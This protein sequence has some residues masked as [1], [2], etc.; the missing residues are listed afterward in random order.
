MPQ[1]VTIARIVSNKKLQKAPEAP[2]GGPVNDRLH[3]PLSDRVRQDDRN[4]DRFAFGNG[5]GACAA[6]GSERSIRM[7]QIF[8]ADSIAGPPRSF[9]GS[10]VCNFFISFIALQISR[11]D[12]DWLLCED[13]NHR[14]RRRRRRQEVI[15]VVEVVD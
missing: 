3:Y 7:V 5:T 6:A 11:S 12:L 13:S 8:S 2:R 4:D 10:L 15:P 9:A 14:R 1:I